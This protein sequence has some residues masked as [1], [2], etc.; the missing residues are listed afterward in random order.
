MFSTGCARV[1]YVGEGI[2]SSEGF[3]LLELVS[4]SAGAGDRRAMDFLLLSLDLGEESQAPRD[5]KIQ[6]VNT[7]TVCITFSKVSLD[8]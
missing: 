1:T 3:G 4:L 8:K 5:G 2:C 7:G 6:R